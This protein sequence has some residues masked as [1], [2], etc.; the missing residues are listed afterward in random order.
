MGGVWHT[1][2]HTCASGLVMAG[3]DIRLV[4]EIMGHKTLAMTMRYSH[5]SGGHLNEAINRISKGE[6]S[7]RT[8]T[9]TD[10]PKSAVREE[11]V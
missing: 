8:D 6:I 3:V 10:K 9:Q 2:R 11:V 4:Q 1:L 5:L 7:E